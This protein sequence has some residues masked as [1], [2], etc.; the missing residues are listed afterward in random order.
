M[1]VVLAFVLA[2]IGA[3]QIALI[4]P[5]MDK[6]L[7]P[8]SS[9]R[10]VYILAAQLVGLGLLNFPC[11]F[12]HFYWL[13]FI[14]DKATCKIREDVY[15][16]IVRLPASFYEKSKQGNLIAYVLNDSGVFANGFRATID[17]IRE[18][19]K[20]IAYL[21]MA[22]YSDWQ[23]TLVIF[24]I[25]PILIGIFSISGKK[26]HKNQ[27]FVQGTYALLTHNL[28]EM[29]SAQKVVKAFSLQKFVSRRF[30]K[31][32]D[33]FLESQVKT[34]FVEEV[35]HPFV[36]LLGAMAFGAVI[37]FAHHR[38]QVGELTVGEFISFIGALALFMD[39]M[40]KFSQANVKL[41]QA[42]AALSRIDEI[43]D[44]EDEVNEGSVNIPNFEKEINV[45]NLSFSYGD[46]NVLSNINLTIKK[47]ER[48]GF[49][50][51]SGSGK[52]TLINLLLRIYNIKNGEILIDGHK[53]KDI[54][55]LNLRSI[56]GL[57][58]Q[59]IF[60]FNDTIKTNLEL[61]KDL[62]SDAVWKSLEIAY[63]KEFV[64]E[65]PDKDLQVV[66]DRGVRLSGGQKQ[67]ITIARSFLR[68]PDILLFDEATSALDNESEKIVQKALD[69]IAKNKTVIAV[70]HRLSTIQNFDRIYVFSEGQ[71]IE[72]GNHEELLAKKGEYSK[73]YELSK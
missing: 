39:P 50:G 36:E 71:I 64:N 35:A 48:I 17:L 70:A 24:V 66:G 19:L 18:P 43:L 67:R 21:G 4:R 2:A 7:S 1:V 8:D 63:A 41:N 45:K 42:Q 54:E 13:R 47:G 9:S 72:Q 73:L 56:F 3:L 61:G 28:A 33:D 20:A 37:V 15:Q 57:V 69:D 23:L 22:F 34:T 59:D 62:G 53:I 44:Q 60:L 26:V 31:S 29:I 25:I 27:K 51:L 55:L 68:N 52:S 40:R 58:S 46:H 16:K 10:E 6:G 49:V 38:I 11:R 12:F 14:V 30:K 65:L 32:Q 5:L